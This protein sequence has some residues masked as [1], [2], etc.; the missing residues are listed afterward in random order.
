MNL[1]TEQYKIKGK[2]ETLEKVLTKDLQGLDK[3]EREFLITRFI[4]KLKDIDSLEE[5]EKIEDTYFT[6]NCTAEIKKFLNQI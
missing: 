6:C 5:F 3:D 1:L 4:S 2:L